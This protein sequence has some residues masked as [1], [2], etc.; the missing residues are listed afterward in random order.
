MITP[1]HSSYDLVV[2]GGG[3]AGFP[4]AIQA[5]RNGSRV[6]LVE[7]SGML[8][9]AT[10]LNRVAFPGLFSA[11]GKQIIAGIG[12]DLV[13]AA[14]LESGHTLPDFTQLPE[15][16]WHHQISLCP[17][18]L[19][20]TLDQAVIDSGC[21]LLFHTL[22]AA[23]SGGQGKDWQL[24]LCGKEGLHTVTAKWL[25]D[26]TGDANL[27]ALAGCELSPP[28]SSL[29]PATLVFRME[30]YELDDLNIEAIDQQVPEALASGELHSSDLGWGAKSVSQLLYTHGENA[31]HIPRVNAT[32]S[33][34]KT[35]AEI[36]GRQSV[37]RVF[38]FLKKQPGLEKLKIDWCAPECGIRE[39][40]S[41]IGE[42]TISHQDYQT[43]R[44]WDDAVCYS[45][46]PIDLHTDEG[47]DCRKLAPGT[48]PT[49]P[50]SAMTPKGVKQFLVAGRCISG[51]R[52]ANSAFR[53]QASSM[54]MGQAVGAVASCAVQAGLHHPADLPADSWKQAIRKQGGIVPATD[55]L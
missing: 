18:V 47:L 53:V 55:L 50:L 5:A 21:D 16:H 24:V 13:R 20:A 38:R 40:R 30:G 22:P 49:L 32:S 26:C 17:T 35:Q 8:G 45:F 23:V 36:A 31:I 48:F 12:W 44:L 11:W 27:A 28:A 25:I 34:G 1:P 41:I 19:A 9:G 42:S 43:G 4:A 46:Y 6:L 52:L 29:Q 33:R 3:P 51:D 15:R 2:C 14:A 37:M 54:A 10:T 7:K 39:T